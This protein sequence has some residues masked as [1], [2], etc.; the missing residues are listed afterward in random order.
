MSSPRRTIAFASV[1]ARWRAPLMLLHRTMSNST[2]PGPHH[3]R[4]PRRARGT[5]KTLGCRRVL[6]WPI[7]CPFRVYGPRIEA[8]SR[9]NFNTVPNE[10][11]TP[12]APAYPN[13]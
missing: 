6:G 9:P 2:D 12:V 4:L 3:A 5:L 7:G 8:M 13:C 1:R 11:L 10:G